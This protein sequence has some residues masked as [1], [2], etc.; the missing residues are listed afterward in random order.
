ME[1]HIVHIY[2]SRMKESEFGLPSLTAIRKTPMFLCFLHTFPLHRVDT[3]V[4][5]HHIVSYR[6]KSLKSVRLM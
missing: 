5:Q 4:W 1:I 3:E 6:F 2:V